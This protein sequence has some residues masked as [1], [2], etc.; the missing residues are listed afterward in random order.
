MGHN[1]RLTRVTHRLYSLTRHPILRGIV[2]GFGTT[3]T[4]DP[5]TCHRPLPRMA[6]Q[7]QR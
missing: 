6:R 2:R 3:G 7:K 1:F 4:L 5:A